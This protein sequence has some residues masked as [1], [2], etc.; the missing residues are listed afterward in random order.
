MVTRTGLEAAFFQAVTALDEALRS[1]ERGF[2]EPADATSP[3]LTAPDAPARRGVATALA[4][5]LEAVGRLAAEMV[6]RGD[7]PLAHELLTQAA[8]IASAS[9]VPSLA[10]SG[11]KTK[12]TIAQYAQ[13]RG[14]S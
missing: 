5:Y 2:T 14:G 11:Q 8:Q 12:G 10:T 1:P 7:G 3:A 9:T 6:A 4:A 13:E